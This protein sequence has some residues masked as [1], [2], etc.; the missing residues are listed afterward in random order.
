MQ[1]FSRHRLTIAIIAACAF[2][3]GF[4]LSQAREEIKRFTPLLVTSKTVMDEPIVYPAGTAQLTAGILALAP[5][6][7]TGWHTHGVPLAGIVLEGDLI[8]DYGDKGTR[9]FHQGESIAETINVPH[10]GKAVGPGAVKIFVIYMGAQGLPTVVKL[11][12]K[13]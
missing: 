13:P 10:N 5:G 12:P 11:P 9:T 2:A 6:E 1:M 4:G 3:A 7:E 8:V